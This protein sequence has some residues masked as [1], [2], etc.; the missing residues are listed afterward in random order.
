MF[1]INIRESLTPATRKRLLIVFVLLT[2]AGLLTDTII[3]YSADC[4]LCL[5]RERGIEYHFFGIR[6]FHRQTPSN[7]RPEQIDEFPLPTI[8]TGDPATFDALRGAPC[9][10]VFKR[11]GFGRSSLLVGGA[12]CG[13][14]SEGP[15]FSGRRYA[16]SALHHL[17]KRV[18]DLTL[19][20]ESLAVIDRTFPADLSLDAAVHSP[21]HTYPLRDISALLNLITTESEWR[22]ALGGLQSGP[23]TALPFLHDPDFLAKRLQS[24]DPIVRQTSASLITGLNPMP[25]ARFLPMLLASPDRV[26][27]D[28]AAD[29]ILANR[30]LEFFGPMLRAKKIQP[31]SY[32]FKDYKEPEIISLLGQN[33]PVVDEFCFTAITAG[34]RLSMIDLVV[35]RLNER[36]TPAALNTIA[37]LLRGPTPFDNNR[38]PWENID[39]LPLLGPDELKDYID[40]GTASKVRDPRKWKFLNAVKG[41]AANG[42]AADWD[43]LHK[44]Y[45]RAV[46][47][48]VNETY[49]A[50]MAKAL[51]T[52]DPHRT[53][54]LLVD[55][56]Q[57]DDHQRQSAALVGMG[58]IAEAGFA[59]AIVEFSQNPPAAS[60]KN[61]YPAAVI[62][63][64]HHYARFLAYALH[65]TQGIHRWQLRKDE[66]GHYILLKTPES[67][68][69]SSTSP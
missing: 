49:C 51:M 53:R 30:R 47:G 16:L 40:V 17:Y 25:E 52:L 50:V 56:L 60:S 21:D 3:D 55:E 57:A 20:R 62:F 46:T 64:N 41:L 48:G 14:Y 68:P 65:R 4:V 38:D 37:A 44:A 39:S 54:R 27:V 6:V 12:A 32:W 1:G 2:I 8:P 26:V 35:K 10:H 67:P 59:P 58:L 69:A 28:R 5:R 19:A 15:A 31:E 13:G 34:E 22:L 24:T 11:A 45:L 29:S 42:D 61:H 18:P 66:D 36:Q 33:D 23:A 7:Y 43:F 9:P 63:K